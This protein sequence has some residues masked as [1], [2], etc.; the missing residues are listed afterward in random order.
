M[1][2]LLLSAPLAA[3]LAAASL[4]AGALARQS[5]ATSPIDP[6]R[7]LD[8]IKFLAADQ[9]EGRANG[10]AGLE[11]AADYIQT[12]FN[13]AG[14][15]PAGQNGDWFQPLELAAGLRIG[16]D[17]AL[18][19]KARAESARLSLGESYFPLA[20]TPS[21]SRTSLRDLPVVF[22]GYGISAPAFNY[23]DYERLD[24]KG[25]A[26]LIFSHE[27]QERR[28]DSRLNGTRPLRET[29]LSAKALAAHSRGAVALLVVSDPSHRTDEANYRAFLF[30]SDAEDVG[31][32]VLRVRRDDV[33]PLLKELDLDGLAAMIERDLVPQSRLLAGVTI[34]YTQALF[35]NV[36]TVRNVVG[37]LPG[38][39]N[40]KGDEAVVLGGHY[41][42]VGLGGR[43]SSTPERTGE[44][45]NGAD[46]N[47]S[48]VAALIEIARAAAA[49]PSRFPRSL[50]FIAFAGE[51]RGLL[52]SV[53]Y[54]NH[55]SIP[56]ADTVAMLNLDMVGRARGRVEVGG[57]TTAVSIR[58]DVDAAAKVA[59]IDVRPGGPGAGRSD[60]SSFLDRRVPSLHFFTG[61][62]DDY[63][64]PGDDWPRIDAAGTARVATL[65]LEL[66]ARLAARSDK[67]QFAG[68]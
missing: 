3:L 62:H 2:R 13:R 57:L 31:I 5:A 23:D 25:K 47:A 61:F 15:R 22:A 10:G 56:L 42:H 16:D 67:P 30:A 63:H 58:D 38:A 60:D 66:A 41:D 54:T 45:H 44:I 64:A 46:D 55:P 49:N 24:V 19:V 17:N 65:A 40:A 12:E 18:V 7:I 32:P 1:R 37:M 34:D 26:V 20:A 52:G 27:P 9:L 35:A 59:G 4:G 14:L 11:R 39:D 6:D 68:R 48:G 33:A 50:V 53:H 36:R 8:H 29:T 21:E 28:A 51:E 43:F